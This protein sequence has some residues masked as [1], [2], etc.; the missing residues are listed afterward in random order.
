ML[1]R[2]KKYNLKSLYLNLRLFPFLDAIK[3]PIVV[4]RRTLIKSV[5]RG[6]TNI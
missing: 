3:F 4:D 2:L 6:G 1:N 5:Y